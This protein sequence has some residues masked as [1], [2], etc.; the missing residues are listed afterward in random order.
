MWGTHTYKSNVREKGGKKNPGITGEVPLGLER[1]EGESETEERGD[2]NGHQDPVG[3]VVDGDARDP[4]RQGE[5]EDAHS[6]LGTK[7]QQFGRKQKNEE[8]QSENEQLGFL[9]WTFPSLKWKIYYSI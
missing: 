2:A 8:V 6:D 7:N 4:E 3:V 9:I 5:G 1:E